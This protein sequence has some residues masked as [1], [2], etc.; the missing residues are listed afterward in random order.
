MVK[1]EKRREKEKKEEWWKIKKKIKSVYITIGILHILSSILCILYIC[2][3]TLIIYCV[4]N[5]S[6]SLSYYTQK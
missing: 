5:T 1:R 2:Y 4:Y 3:F 6:L